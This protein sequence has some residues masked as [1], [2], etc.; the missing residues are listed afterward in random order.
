MNEGT[1]ILENTTQES[2][3]FQGV[4]QGT[5]TLRLDPPQV[6]TLN[7]DKIKDLDDVKR[8]L[9]FLNIRISTNNGFTQQGFDKVEDL[10]D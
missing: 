1:V 8:I 4:Y 3:I 5:L 9:R 6:K 2:D 10:F 7:V